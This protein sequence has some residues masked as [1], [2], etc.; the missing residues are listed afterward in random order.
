[1]PQESGKWSIASQANIYIVQTCFRILKCQISKSQ[2]MSMWLPSG[3]TRLVC[4]ILKD[5]PSMNCDKLVELYS[6]RL[7]Q[8][9]NWA[10]C[11]VS[12]RASR[13]I[14]SRFSTV[15]RKSSSLCLWALCFC[16][17][18]NAVGPLLCITE[19]PWKHCMSCQ[20]AKQDRQKPKLTPGIAMTQEDF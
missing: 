14:L 3:D 15:C 10:S 8:L 7:Q 18:A 5:K 2:A 6:M 1:M 20:W 17:A 11:K 13:L 16:K 19:A 4:D 12:S 9:I